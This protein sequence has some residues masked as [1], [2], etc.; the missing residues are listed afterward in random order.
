MRELVVAGGDAAPLLDECE[1]PLDDVAVF[2]GLGIECGRPAAL[3]A[4]AFAGGDLIALLGDHDP[5]ATGAE[6]AP[7]HAGPIGFVREDRV[8][9]GAGAPAADPGN[10]DVVKDLL[11]HRPVVALPAGDHDRQRQTVPVDGVMDLRGQPAPRATDTV[12]GG[13]D[14]IQPQILVIRS[15]PLCPGQGGWCSSRADA[16]ARSSHPPTHPNRSGPPRLPARAAPAAP[17]PMS[18]LRHTGGAAS[19]SSATGRTRL[20]AHPATASRSGTG[21]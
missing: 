11:E 13:F 14:L 3:A 12:T 5:D 1:G 6:H 18:R 21:R 2:V 9:P 17:D 15:C 7:V 19:R 16:H 10:A 4:L 20:A 8:R